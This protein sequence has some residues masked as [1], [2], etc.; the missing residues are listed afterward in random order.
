MMAL[1]IVFVEESEVEA[2]SLIGLSTIDAM[3]QLQS[4]GLKARVD[5]VDS[6]QPEGA[7]ISQSPSPGIRIE[8]GKI[9]VLRVSRGGM[10]SQVPDVR[11]MEFAAAVRALDTAGFKTGSV[12]KVTDSLKPSGTVIAQNPAS[13]AMV[14]NNRMV[15]LLVSEGKTG[16]PENVLVPDLKGQTEEL[17]WQ[18]LSQSDLSVSKVIQVESTAV[19]EGAIVRT[20]PRAGTRVPYGNALIL[21][22]AKIAEAPI[23]IGVV[24]PEPRPAPTPTPNPAP[25]PTP[26]VP[27]PAPT[28]Q[29]EQREADVWRPEEGSKT[30]PPLTT[31]SG[32]GGDSAA[33]PQPT[34]TPAPT[35]SPTPAP[36]PTPPVGG[37]TARINYVVPLLTRPLPL[38]IEMTDEAG[39]KVLRSQEVKGGEYISMS[40]AYAGKATITVRLGDQAVWQQNFD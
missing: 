30:L 17:A 31:G 7:V 23:D 3:N 20:Q 11:G 19:P 33:T 35:P 16:K 9:M 21:Y 28:P 38:R 25:V 8:R 36:A 4:L 40:P 24:P 1:R 12:L 32:Q 15:D 26:P 29:R 14:M 10:R 5:Q 6:D 2:P 39:T 34:P 22:V 27:T 13:P 37:K 18:I